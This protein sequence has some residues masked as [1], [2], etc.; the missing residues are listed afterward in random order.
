MTQKWSSRKSER[1]RDSFETD[2]DTS[3]EMKFPM[4]LIHVS[5]FL[6]LAELEPYHVLREAK[7]L[8]PWNPEMKRVIFLSHQWTSFSHPDPSLEQLR[9][10][11]RVLLRMMSGDMPATAPCFADAAYLP[12]GISISTAEWTEIVSD[13][14]IWMECAAR[15]AQSPIPI[16]AQPPLRLPPQLLFGAAS[17]RV[18]QHGRR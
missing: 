9:V 15:H 16:D 8:V 6:R 1:R 17:R 11:Q 10:V 2:L 4:W 3:I 5:D 12:S 7:K 14:Y 13:A 18:P